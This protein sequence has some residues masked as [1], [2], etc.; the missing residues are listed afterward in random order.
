MSVRQFYIST[1][2]CL[3][4][5]SSA[6]IASADTPPSDTIKTPV[7]QGLI[8]QFL[9]GLTV[10]GYYRGY[11]YN[12]SMDH[13]YGTPTQPVG[14]K[15][16]IGVGDGYYDPM[17]FLYI[18]GNAT[19]NTSFGTEVIVANP[20]DMY[21]GPGYSTPGKVNPYFTAVLRGSFATKKG[22]LSVIAG[23]IE[24][25]RLT[26]FTFGANVG[27]NRYSIFERRPWDPV[28]NIKTRYAS[29]YYSGNINQDSR[30]GTQAFKGFMLQGYVNAIKT[31]IDVFYGKT[32]PNG[33]IDR[34]HTVRPSENVGVRI[35]KNFKNKDYV[36]LNT[37]NSISRSD[38]INGTND[39]QWNI[40]TTEF[41]KTFKDITLNGEIGMG[42][43]VSPT[44][45][46]NWSLGLMA[47]L[48]IPKKYTLIP[49]GIRYY[50][51]GQS[52]TSNVANFNNTTVR[53]VN[54]GY[55]GS[56]TPI[57]TPYGSTMDNTGD[58]ANNRRGVAL[59]TQFK[60]LSKFVVSIGTQVSAEM[61]KLPADTML[62]YNHRIN[63]LVWSRIPGVYPLYN[64]FGP[65]NRVGTYYRGAYE[66]VH[67]TEKNPDGTPSYRRH[68]NS[69]DLQIKYKTK[70]FSKDLYINYLGTFS[71]AQN[72]FSVVTKFDNSAYLRAQ[73]Q[74]LDVYYQIHRNLILAFYGGL[75][76]IQGNYNTDL[77]DVLDANGNKILKPRDQVGTALGVGIDFSITGNTTLILRDRIFYFNDKNFVNETFSGN[78]S[79][80]ELKIYF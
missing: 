54:T 70:L 16:T 11:F 57:S 43:Y 58:L 31:N 7:S 55:N 28:D 80:L 34:E 42:R 39:V 49:L 74:E 52:F 32:G 17:L 44:Y 35:K 48:L 67:I 15:K 45:A 19:Q 33:G 53:E 75:E 13:M 62:F 68:F 77:G 79:T 66:Q 61:E 71:S 1:I 23:G 41:S 72:Y 73:Y 46:E 2:L 10:G 60:V 36:S 50:Q 37:F 5:F 25:M 24:W 76:T 26:P 9:N 4:C 30:W 3:L 56:G 78:E 20:F 8:P 38:S 6:S 18:G 47:D 27:F 14:A 40:I 22:T 29:Y 51:I 21:H 63:G 65:H 12:R 64:T 59:N 69:I